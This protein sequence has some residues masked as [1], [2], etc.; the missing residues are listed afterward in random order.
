MSSNLPVVNQYGRVNYAKK[1]KTA[2]NALTP[3]DI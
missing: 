2:K 1:L 3:L